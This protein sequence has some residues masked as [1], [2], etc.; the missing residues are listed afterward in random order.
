M[1]RNR[2]AP[3]AENL[4]T[5][6]SA[7]TNLG[8]NEKRSLTFLKK[9]HPRHPGRDAPR[10]AEAPVAG[11]MELSVSEPYTPLSAPIP[12]PTSV[13]VSTMGPSIPIPRQKDMI[14]ILRSYPPSITGWRH[15]HNR[16]LDLRRCTPLRRR[17]SKGRLEFST[18]PPPFTRLMLTRKR[19][20][21]R[22]FLLTIGRCSCKLLPFHW[23]REVVF[24]I[25]TNTAEWSSYPF[26]QCTAATSHSRNSRR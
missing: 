16:S 1:E 11:A 18:C 24:I 10:Q 17:H 15:R 12:R 5:T 23:G 9:P 19:S 8:R 4:Q 26:E 2:N 6:W 21:C 22:V 7:F 20:G 14:Q 25:G 3:R 13:G